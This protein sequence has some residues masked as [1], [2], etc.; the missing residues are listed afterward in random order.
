M[1]NVWRQAAVFRLT[2]NHEGRCKRVDV[3]K[4]VALARDYTSEITV[5]VPAHG[6]VCL[7]FY[8]PDAN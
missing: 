6:R 2:H 3:R 1:L 4:I 8:A 7:T 5:T